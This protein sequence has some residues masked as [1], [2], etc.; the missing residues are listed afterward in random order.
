LC[1]S[2]ILFG[3]KHGS[4]HYLEKKKIILQRRRDFSASLSLPLARNKE[5]AKI[6]STILIGCATSTMITVYTLP[7]V[8]KRWL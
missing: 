4:I 8:R 5:N 6:L 3:I 7:A 2:R 1:L